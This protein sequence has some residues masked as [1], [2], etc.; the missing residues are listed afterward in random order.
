MKKLRNTHLIFAALA[1]FCFMPRLHAHAILLA[2]APAANETVSGAPLQIRLRFNARIDSKRSRLSLLL[3][4]GVER[5]LT[6]DQPS[7]DTVTSDVAR[8]EPGAYV[9]RWQVLAEDG[10]IT[11]GELP[12]RAK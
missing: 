10:H 9:I 11:R 3:P 1:S 4:D 5:A 12:F 2:A 6:T 7:P 8:L